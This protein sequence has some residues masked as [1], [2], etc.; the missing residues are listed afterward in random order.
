MY[1]PSESDLLRRARGG[2]GAAFAGLL[3]P[4]YL[5]AF[6][7]AYGMVHDLNEAEDIV[8]EASLTAW[9]R[10][11]N[12]RE[13]MP[14]RPWLL[15]IVAN[16]CRAAAKRRRWSALLGD[17][18]F[19][20]PA[21]LAAQIDLRRALSRLGHDDRVVLL[22]RYYLDMPFDEIALAVHISPKGAR[23]RVHRALQGLRPMLQVREAFT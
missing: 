18:V 20:E 4:L 7:L 22:L 19:Q 6:R 9:R 11:C 1:A 5:A 13:G 2:D 12:V 17:Q 10:V 16:R 21:D 15:A 14:L 23:S 8:Q 3:Q